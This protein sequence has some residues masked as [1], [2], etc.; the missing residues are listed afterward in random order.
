MAVVTWS[1][2]LRVEVKKLKLLGSVKPASHVSCTTLSANEQKAVDG[3][4][5]AKQKE[6]TQP[7]LDYWR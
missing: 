7:K 3:I 2:E 4:F 1:P 6:S 5:S